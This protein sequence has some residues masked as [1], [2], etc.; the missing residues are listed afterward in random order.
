MCEENDDIENDLIKRPTNI[1]K[2]HFTKMSCSI[3]KCHIV[4]YKAT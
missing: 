2:R 3:G 4:N 1:K